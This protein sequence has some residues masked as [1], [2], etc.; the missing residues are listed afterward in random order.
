MAF[1]MVLVVACGWVPHILRAPSTLT[2]SWDEILL[3]EFRGAGLELMSAMGTVGAWEP[4]VILLVPSL[5]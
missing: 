1:S 3:L 2:L 4:G 5:R